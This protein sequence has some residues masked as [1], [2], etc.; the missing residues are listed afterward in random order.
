MNE[1]ERC[2]CARGSSIRPMSMILVLIFSVPIEIYVG[3]ALIDYAS[4]KISIVRTS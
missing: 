3:K 4:T 1:E 2:R